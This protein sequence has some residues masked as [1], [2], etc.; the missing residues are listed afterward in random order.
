VRVNRFW[1]V[2][3]AIAAVGLAVRVAYVAF[4]KAGDDMVGDQLFY[5]AAANRLLEDGFVEPFNPTPPPIKGTGPAADHPPLTITVLGPVSTLTD[6]SPVAHRL[7]MA[8]LGTAV[9]VLLGLLG[10]ELA[11]DRAGIGAL[12]PNLWVNDGLVM[13][14]TLAALTVSLSLLLAY[15]LVRAP[16]AKLAVLVGLAVGLGTLARAELALLVPFLAVPAALTA[17]SVALGQRVRL[18][19]ITV[20]VAGVLVGPWVVA[21]VVRFE[22]PTFLSTND[23]IA[24]LGSNCDAVFSDEGTGLTSFECLEPPPPGDQSVQS[25]EYRDAAFEYMGDNL[26]RVPLVMLARAGRTW[27]LWRPLDMITYNEGEG[28]ERWVTTLGLIVWYPLLLAAIAGAVVLWHERRGMLWPLLVPAV[29]V[30]LASAATYGQTRFRV[31]A[32][33]SVVVLAAIAIAA[34]VELQSRTIVASSSS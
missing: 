15:R 34:L 16:S 27:S 31:P 12:Y 21:N 9:V 20:V 1:R 24:L 28:R 6:D 23:G 30:T 19:V 22:E 17:R 5:N 14:E 3:L 8:V 18:A 4:D 33:P 32:E 26:T 25:A 29:I 11:G 10:R 13:S 2:L 7:T